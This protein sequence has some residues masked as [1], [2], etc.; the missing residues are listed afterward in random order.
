[1]ESRSRFSGVRDFFYPERSVPV[2]QLKPNNHAASE[3]KAERERDKVQAMRD[4]QA[5]KLAHHAN[6]MRLRALRLAKESSEAQATT[7]PRLATKKPA[8]RSRGQL[9]KSS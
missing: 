9:R 3:L 1:L 7:A 2:V 5:E 8:I 6:M 4:Y